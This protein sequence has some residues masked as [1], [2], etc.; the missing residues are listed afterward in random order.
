MDFSYITEKPEQNSEDENGGNHS[1]MAESQA[2][3]QQKYGEVLVVLV[4]FYC[5][6]DNENKDSFFK[7]LF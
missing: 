6:S 4:Y 1:E 5:R 3:E 2:E 7:S